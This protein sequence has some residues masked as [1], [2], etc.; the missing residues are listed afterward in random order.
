MSATQKEYWDRVAAEKTFSHPLRVEWLVQ[1]LSCPSGPATIIDYGCGYGRTL[2]ELTQAG[3]DRAIGLD[4]S[5]QMLVRSRELLPNARLIHGDGE[6]IPF[7]DNSVDVALLFALLT[8]IPQ[9]SQQQR[10]IQ[11]LLRV[12]RPGGILYISDLMINNDERN[13]ARYQRYADQFGRYG[14]FE[15]PEGVVMRHHNEEWIRDL[16]RPFE[17]LKFERF[18]V[19]TMNGNRSAAFQYLGRKSFFSP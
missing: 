2:A 11:E 18:E 12:L 14:V 4:A 15:L 8:C 7:R 9:D 3:F 13:T 1:S 6:S 5:A 16:T 10:L 17:N 19:V